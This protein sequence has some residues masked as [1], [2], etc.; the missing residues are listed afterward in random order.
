MKRLVTKVILEVIDME[1]IEKGD[2][3][4]ISPVSLTDK[5]IDSKNLY[6]ASNHGFINENGVGTIECEEIGTLSFKYKAQK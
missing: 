6:I 5:Y 2:Y 1:N 3:F 4:T